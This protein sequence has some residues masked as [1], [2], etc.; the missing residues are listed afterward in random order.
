MNRRLQ[1]LK[2]VLIDFSTAMVAWVL[3]FI[4]RKLRL[5]S[6]F[7]TDFWSNISSDANLWKGMSIIPLFWLLLY[8]T[9]G[10]YRKIYRRSRLK[11][12]AETI[13]VSFVGVLCI[14]FVLILDD[15]ILSYKAYYMLFGT[16]FVLHFGLTYLFRLFLTS[17]IVHK[18]HNRE[19]GF[20][21]ILVGNGDIAYSVFKSLEEQ[22]K[23]AGNRF[24]GYVEASADEEDIMN[25][26]LP[27][28]GKF[29]D[30][31]EV[32]QRHGVEEMIVATNLDDKTKLGAALA[33]V[34]GSNVVVKVKPDIK[35]IILGSVKTASV[36]DTP[37]IT[38]SVDLMP[39]WQQSLK[40]LMDIVFSIIAMVLLIPVYVF[41]AIGVKM[42][43]KG[44]IFYSQERVGLNGV[45]FKM[46]KFRSMYTDAEKDGKPR[47][48]SDH[49][50]RI[51]PFGRFMRKVRLDEIPQFYSV[52]IGDMALVGPRPERQYFV[53]KISEH[54]PH[55]RLLSKI[56][57]GI[58]SWGQVKYGYASSVEEMIERMKFDLLY[59][60]NMSLLMDIKILIYTVMIVLQGRG[61]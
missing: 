50:P 12:L 55:Y 28:L 53:D 11:E 49:D 43:S 14:F 60:E 52:L 45:H 42:S 31:K 17:S 25:K 10:F 34:E 27:N 20:N 57:P 5:E 33:V 22:E 13:A 4:I 8:Y 9:T 59:I 1:V 47:L 56:K 39:P 46:H 36:F 26:H 24:V 54:A 61:K 6:D 16:L 21:T 32:I 35:D 29:D 44:P 48:S 37:L 23:S 7:I 58:T 18:I 41:T 15:I 30:L 2:Y 3:F 19:Y 40:R 51:T 38:I